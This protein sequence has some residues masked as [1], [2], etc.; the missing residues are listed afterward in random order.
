MPELHVIAMLYA[1]AG[2]EREMRRDLAAITEASR[3]EDGN[4]SY[5]LF[6]DQND[7]RRFV[8][9]EHWRDAAA[10][11]RHHNQSDHIRHFHE[12]GERNVERREAVH[13]LTK[14]V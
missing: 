4:I 7:P 11:D 14:V 2:Q 3:N 1:R 12:N 10:Q 6:E 8:L 5:D 9:V 13:F